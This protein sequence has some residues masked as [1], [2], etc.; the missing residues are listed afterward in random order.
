MRLAMKQ[1]Y[2]FANI[3]FLGLGNMGFPMAC[4]LA[5]KGHKVFGYDV[6]TSKSSEAK[7]KNII[8]CDKI[9]DLTR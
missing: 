8:F 2:S 1:V 4:N 5:S 7:T 6:D 3:G 9:K